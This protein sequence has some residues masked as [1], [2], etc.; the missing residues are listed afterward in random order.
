MWTGECVNWFIT[1]FKKS[2]LSLSI[3]LTRVQYKCMLYEIKHVCTMENRVC[4]NT[5]LLED[6]YD[7]TF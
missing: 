4:L 2:P 3:Y 6:Y 1:L 5:Y 7:L